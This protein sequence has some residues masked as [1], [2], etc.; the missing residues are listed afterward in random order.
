VADGILE[1]KAAIEEGLIKDYRDP[2]YSNH[3]SLSE[4]GNAHLIYQT[5]ITPLYACDLAEKDSNYDKTGNDQ[6][7]R[8]GGMDKI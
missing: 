5:H 3:K 2:K 6:S 8:E 4:E 7:K 1:I